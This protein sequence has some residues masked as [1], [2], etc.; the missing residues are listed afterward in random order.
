VSESCLLRWREVAD[1]E[2]MWLGPT[3]GTTE[4]TSVTRYVTFA[5]LYTYFSLCTYR[6]YLNL[7]TSLC[8]IH[9]THFVKIRHSLEMLYFMRNCAMGNIDDGIFCS[10]EYHLFKI[11]CFIGKKITMCLNFFKIPCCLRKNMSNHLPFQLESLLKNKFVFTKGKQ[12][13]LGNKGNV[14]FYASLTLW[15]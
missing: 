13:I 2:L 1:K 12:Y 8:W 10:M 9:L 7:D 11:N 14:P 4:A 6:C 15:Q 3:E 5:Y